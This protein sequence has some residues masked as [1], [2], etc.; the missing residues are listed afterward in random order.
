M[1]VRY[2]PHVTRFLVLLGALATPPARAELPSFDAFFQSVSECR[3]DIARYGEVIEP[4]RDGVLISL[5]FAGAMRGFLI[6]SFYLAS[7]PDGVDQY[8]LLF[9]GPLDAVGKA[10]PEL[11]ARRTMNGYLRRLA[12]LAEQ[13]RDRGASRKTLLICIAGTPT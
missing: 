8:G 9:N 7:G 5:P 4:T 13:S 1:L 11:A 2:M 10:F 12:S 6:D 3:L